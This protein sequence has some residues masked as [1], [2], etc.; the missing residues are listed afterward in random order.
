MTATAHK[1][2]L[3][4]HMTIGT[5]RVD[6]ASGGSLDVVNPA[7]GRSHGTP[8]PNASADE[9]G[10][11]VAAAQTALPGWRAWSPVDRRRVMLR[12]AELMRANRDEL[13]VLATLET[14]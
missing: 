10:A 4:T 14:G 11:A 12:L 2:D 8:V 9:V 13:S 7:T 3:P 1:V 6:T 5:D